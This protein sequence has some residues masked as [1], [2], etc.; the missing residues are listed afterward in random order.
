MGFK[1]FVNEHQAMSSSGRDPQNE[2]N[3]ITT[4]QPIRV[5]VMKCLNPLKVNYF[6]WISLLH[7]HS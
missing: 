3:D 2:I 6:V 5:H 1:L 4:F 7:R